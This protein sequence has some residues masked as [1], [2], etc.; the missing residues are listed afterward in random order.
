MMDVRVWQ[1][2]GRTCGASYKIPTSTR[3]SNLDVRREEI[4]TG[5]FFLVARQRTN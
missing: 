3:V 2:D 4:D 5:M 1:H